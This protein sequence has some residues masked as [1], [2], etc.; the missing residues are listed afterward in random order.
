MKWLLPF[1][2]GCILCS[3]I[4]AQKDVVFQQKF[5]DGNFQ[6]LYDRYEQAL[7]YFL[8]LS[9]SYPKNANISYRLGECYMN[10]PG[11]KVAAIPYLE[12]AAEQ[13]GKRY[14]PETHKEKKAP[15]ESLFLLGIA[16]R[17][18]QQLDK[19]ISQFNKY[20]NLVQ[21]KPKEVEMANH[22]IEACNRAR[23]MLANPVSPFQA[24]S[25]ELREAGHYLYQ[26]CLSLDGRHMVFMSKKTYYK[27]IYFTTFT[28]GWSEPVNITAQVE[29]DGSY[30]CVSLSPDGYTLFLTNPGSDN[31]DIFVSFYSG[32]RWSRLRP[33]QGEVNTRSRETYAILS[34]D[35]RE[36]Y[37]TSDRKEGL[38]GLDIY[39]A[40]HDSANYFTNPR[41]LG[42][43]INTP[44]NEATP[45]LTR[46]GSLFFSSDRHETMGGYDVFQSYNRDGKWSTP[47]NA[48]YPIS[49]TD[50]DLYFN[51][52]PEDKLAYASLFTMGQEVNSQIYLYDFSGVKRELLTHVVGV[53]RFPASMERRTLHVFLLDQKTADT[54]QRVVPDAQT[55]EYAM[56]VAPGSYTLTI[57][58]DGIVKK[59]IPLVI[60]SMKQEEYYY[61]ETFLESTALQSQ[62]VF[63][64]SPVYFSFDKS[65]LPTEATLYL[66]SLYAI[67]L[68]HPEITLQVRG[69]CDG[70][71]T[72]AYNMTLSE[73]RAKAVCNYLIS[74]GI[75]PARLVL[76]FFGESMPLARNTFT[77]GKDC[78]E[79]RQFNRRVDFQSLGSTDTFIKPKEVQVPYPLQL[80]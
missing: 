79:G 57:E 35:N 72:E 25:V 63:L 24:D 52:F 71:G 44:G 60:P 26:P 77:N 31:Q 28:T 74:K 11:M 55:G 18:D 7:P 33:L 23:T 10:I 3:S 69:H 16:Y 56:N 61:Q 38:G 14:R 19:A 58:G 1:L 53:T 43:P 64:L 75:S 78:P 48:G 67:L 32:S 47:V 59:T 49:T 42:N 73:K 51:P 45:F 12:K 50:D 6:M 13:L 65:S 17:A 4:Q 54:L 9:R 8:D 41:N 40:T 36:L 70:I 76:K 30:E 2:L 39:V 27:A 22:E 80:R 21:D 34:P 29:S 20:K 5:Y 68:L 46:D 62:V 66:D 15:F 37:F